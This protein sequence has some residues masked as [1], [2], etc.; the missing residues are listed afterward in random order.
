MDKRIGDE[1]F[2]VYRELLAEAPPDE[3][4]QVLLLL[5]RCLLEAEQNELTTH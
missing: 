4:R 2:R 1:E 3:Q 5:I